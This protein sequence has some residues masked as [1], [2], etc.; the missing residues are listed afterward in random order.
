M[1]ELLLKK[2]QSWVSHEGNMM[3]YKTGGTPWL[4]VINPEGIVI[5]NDFSIHVD[6]AIQFLQEE[7]AKRG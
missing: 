6:K 7:K 5:F 1:P 3:R 2:A 4:V